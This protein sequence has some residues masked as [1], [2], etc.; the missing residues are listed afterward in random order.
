R[1]ISSEIILENLL[2]RL[3]E[4]AIENAGAERGLCLQQRDVQLIVAAGGGSQAGRALGSTPDGIEFRLALSVVNYVRSTGESMVT[5]NAATDERFIGDPYV[6]AVMPKSILCVPMIYQ[7]QSEGILYLENNLAT[8]A[9]PPE[10]VRIMHILSAQAAISL[11]NATLYKERRR[12]QAALKESEAKY[13]DL[14]ENAPDMFI[15][16]DAANAKIIRCNR[17]FAEAI[18]YTRAEILGRPMFDMYHPG[19]MAQVRSTFAEFKKTGEI[20]NAELQLKR[21]DGG[22]IDVMLNSSAVRNAKGKILYS[23]SVWRDITKRKR[24]E[25]ALKR[26]LAEVEQLKNRLQDESAYLQEEI[27][28]THNFEEMVGSSRALRAMLREVEVVAHTD[29]T[30]LILGETGTGKELIARAVHDR[31]PR[32]ERALVKVNCAA[33]SAGLVESELF[34]HVKGA[35]TGALASRTGRFELAKGGTIFLDEIGEL[36]LDTQV[37]LLRVLQEQEFE[38]V[39]SSRTLRV[40]VRVIAATNRNLETAVQE[41]R[42]RADLY[43]RLNVFPVRLP[44]L[45]E[46]REDIPQLAMFFMSRFAKKF[47]KRVDRISQSAIDTLMSYAWPGNIRDLQNVIERAAILSQGS[48]LRIDWELPP[49]GTDP[50]PDGPRS[51][52]R[53]DRSASEI[54]GASGEAPVTLEDVERRHI[55][56]ILNQ[57]RGVIEGAKGAASILKLRP[58][59]LRARMKKLRISRASHESA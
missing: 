5:G 21:K 48:T 18:G 59:T 44:P 30:V 2:R 46:R 52:F 10:R 53:A 19:C 47:G 23:R 9:F 22:T 17:T 4:I 37:K 42:F 38:P 34:G 26:A 28:L 54:E 25:E 39:G 43:Y 20:H 36:P 13:H 24:A 41:G 7:G 11:H 27:K 1:A 57:T 40:D 33:I 45:R 8:D 14:Y 55:I 15:S 49:D 3:M 29:A 31:S 58:S 32:R 56:K 51:S 35:F 6:A 16:V 12:A 50:A